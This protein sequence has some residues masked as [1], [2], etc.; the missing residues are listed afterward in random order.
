M[1][2]RSEADVKSV[3]EHWCDRNRD[4]RSRGAPHR[5]GAP[6]SYEDMKQMVERR[7]IHVKRMAREMDWS[8]FAPI[9]GEESMEMAQGGGDEVDGSMSESE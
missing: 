4:F 3:Y 1:K 9:T 7:G 6:P 8:C 2:D 5:E